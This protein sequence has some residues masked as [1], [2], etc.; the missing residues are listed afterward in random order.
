MIQ[1]KPNNYVQP[2]EVR[3][4]VVQAI[5]EAFTSNY[6]RGRGCR[7]VYH[8][9]NGSNRGCRNAHRYVV[10]HKE[11]RNGI[12]YKVDGLYDNFSNSPT[13][14]EEYLTFNGAEMKRAFE[15]LIKAG[16][17]MFRV[18]EYG[19]WMGYLCN[20]KPYMDWDAASP[21]RVESFD[22]RID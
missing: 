22:D 21:Q 20:D 12:R 17:Y 2:T 3:E 8:P 1:I 19:S 5:C 11:F 9:F 15:E 6:V 7:S 10:R 18:Y 13:D 16:Y 4:E 14:Y